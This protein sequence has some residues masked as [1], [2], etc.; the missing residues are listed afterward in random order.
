MLKSALKTEQKK[1]DAWELIK[2]WSSH[3]TQTRY[4]IDLEAALGIAV[5]R[6]TANKITLE[7]IGWT[8]KEREV[9][10]EQFSHLKFIP[11]V[12]GNYY[13]TRGLTNSIRG[14]VDH[15]E[16]PRELLS[17]WTIK[18]NAEIFRKRQEFDKNLKK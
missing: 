5:R 2:W 18:I 7:S 12:P 1:N 11:I 15:G 14:V 4:A 8:T 17:E 10:K 13:V 16:N 3:E 9:L 6:A